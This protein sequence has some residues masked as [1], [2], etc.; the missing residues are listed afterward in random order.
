MLTK[1]WFK[2]LK[3]RPLEYPRHRWEDNIKMDRRKIGFL[4]VGIRTGGRLS[5]RGNGT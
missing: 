1:F 5:V 4:G 3:E 2:T